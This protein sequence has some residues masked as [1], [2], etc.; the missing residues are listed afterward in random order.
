MKKGTKASVKS[1]RSLSLSAADVES[2]SIN[3]TGNKPD[4]KSDA[5]DSVHQLMGGLHRVGL[6]SQETMRTFD[7]ECLE[8]RAEIR[9][10]EIAAIRRA[11]CMS[12]PVFAAYL[13]TT[14]STVAKWESGE[15]KPSGPS[16]RLLEVVAKHGIKILI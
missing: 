6:I 4:A 12:Q 7:V 5:L 11:A 8:P 13:G 1:T 9:P 2:R 14:K 15:K 16:M 3:S 10:S